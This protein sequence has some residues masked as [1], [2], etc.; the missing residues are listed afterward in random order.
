MDEIPEFPRVVLEALRQ[1]LEDG[2]VT[3]SRAAGTSEFPSKF[4]LIAACNPCPCGF[5]GDSKKNCVCTAHQINTYKKRLSGP[6]LDRI[7]L[8]VFCSSIPAD[9]L[10][11]YDSGE[12]SKDIRNRVQGARNKQQDRYQNL[13]IHSN[14]E[15]SA[16]DIK[17]YCKL[18]DKTT[19]LLHKAIS[20]MNLSARGF[21]RILKVARTIADLAGSDN[22]EMTHVAEALQF[23]PKE[24]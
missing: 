3:V 1:P 17:T 4:I 20:T 7:D 11:T 6:F 23:R 22:I 8:H 24:D 18:D 9:K 21:H 12:K 14:A 16:K 5:L 19:E 13:K 15:L 2:F 10:T